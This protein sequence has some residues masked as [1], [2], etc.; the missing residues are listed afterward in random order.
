MPVAA[1][2]LL[3]ICQ[4]T[5]LGPLAAG[6][7]FF[8]ASPAACVAKRAAAAAEAAAGQPG[9]DLGEQRGTGI[10][11]AAGENARSRG[12]VARDGLQISVKAWGV[13]LHVHATVGHLVHKR[14]QGWLDQPASLQLCSQ[15][16]EHALNGRLSP[17]DP[18][19]AV[20]S[21]WQQKEKGEGGSEQRAEGWDPQQDAGF[22]KAV[23]ALQEELADQLWEAGGLLVAH[24][25]AVKAKEQQGKLQ[26][27]V[28]QN[29]QH[30]LRDQMKACS[31][32]VIATMPAAGSLKGAAGGTATINLLATPGH[33][34][35]GAADLLLFGVGGGE[36]VSS[37]GWVLEAD[38]SHQRGQL[39]QA[40]CSAASDIIKCPSDQDQL[41]HSTGFS[42]DISQQD[43][44]PAA[45]ATPAATTLGKAA[46]TNPTG[47]CRGSSCKGLPAVGIEGHWL[48]SGLAAA[49][50][51]SSVKAE[52][53]MSIKEEQPLQLRQLGAGEE[54]RTGCSGSAAGSC[55]TCHC[56]SDVNSHINCCSNS[57][58]V[59]VRFCGCLN[60]TA[61]STAIK[62]ATVQEQQQQVKSSDTA[63]ICRLGGASRSSS[64]GS[65]RAML[66]GMR[67][68]WGPMEGERGEP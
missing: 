7:S 59:C 40:G 49:A 42:R 47:I 28:T 17:L 10:C 37:A 25:A 38:L 66:P 29:R 24:Y 64:S 11:S 16:L 46:R 33:E 61:C 52:A 48:A 23:A 18:A 51:G 1:L 60:G 26:L 30:N 13:V 56:N 65:S 43:Q 58:A 39:P 50:Q 55:T 41:D 34:L 53:S 12:A 45:S 63:L 27:G 6:L 67:F 21:Q 32:E 44:A 68:D 3:A 20:L 9:R 36:E 14:M 22:L 5:G 2:L 15:W 4:L 54:S 31:L 62:W 8:A 57:S 35:K 19:V